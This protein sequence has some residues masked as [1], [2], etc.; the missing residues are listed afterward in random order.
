MGKNYTPEVPAKYGNPTDWAC[1][2]GSFANAGL[3]KPNDM[4]MIIGRQVFAHA[5]ILGNSIGF[6]PSVVSEV[7]RQSLPS[8][9]VRHVEENPRLA[10]RIANI[11]KA[12]HR[13]A[14][15]SAP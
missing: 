6:S 13:N 3:I 8:W 4:A 5:G 1:M 2:V 7:L 12:A 11:L 10:G 15:L 14:F 9:D